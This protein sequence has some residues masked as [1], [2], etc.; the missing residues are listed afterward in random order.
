MNEFD[1]QLAAVC[2]D[3]ANGALPSSRIHGLCR[4]VFE[5]CMADRTMPG[6]YLRLGD[7]FE[8]LGLETPYP[9]GRQSRGM[10]D[11]KQGE[12]RRDLARRVAEWLEKQ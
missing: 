10:W 6:V 3:F 5:R 1:Q 4:N 12:A 7:A 8:A 11:G 2:R 9:L